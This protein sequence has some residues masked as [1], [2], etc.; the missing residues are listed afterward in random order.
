MSSGQIRA[1]AVADGDSQRIGDIEGGEFLID[2]EKRMHHHLHLLFFGAAITD[3]AHFDFQRRVF[4]DRKAGFGSL[5]Q[6]HAADVRQFQ[7]RLGIDGV[8]DFF[9]GDEPGRVIAEHGAQLG[10]NVFQ[11]KFE[12][13]RRLG[14]N[15]ARGYESVGPAVGID[16][17]EAGALRSAVDT[18]DSHDPTAP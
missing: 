9:D 2:A 12:S 5:E 11:A 8:K 7:G 13:E 17:A 18:D 1:R 3:D 4:T 15:D 6:S 10:G 14:A 16:D